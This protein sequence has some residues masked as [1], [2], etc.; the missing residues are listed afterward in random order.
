M[1]ICGDGIFHFLLN[2]NCTGLENRILGE[3]RT[4][5]LMGTG[6]LEPKVAL[7]LLLLWCVCVVPCFVAFLALFF[8][9]SLLF[10]WVVFIC[11]LVWF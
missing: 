10:V 3:E 11:K 6:G 1:G 4:L 2:C 5:L 7:A 8:V 9:S